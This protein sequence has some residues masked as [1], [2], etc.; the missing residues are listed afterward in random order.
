MALSCRLC[1][2]PLRAD[3][4][5]AVC[6]DWKR[7]IGADDEDDGE[8]APLAAVSNEIVS[9]LRGALRATTGRLRLNAT[10]KDAT[11]RLLKIGNTMSK[12]L[13]S[14]RK[15]QDDGLAA[16]KAM[17][18]A[19]RAELFL[20]WYGAL[21]PAHR[22]SVRGSMASFEASMVKVLPAARVT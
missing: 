22:T 13:E 7:N 9:A 16:V 8:N 1:R 18:F 14:A 12:V 6:L 2:T 17:S 11:D 3:T 15:L 20:G 19:E 4:G 21:P 5:C 10:D